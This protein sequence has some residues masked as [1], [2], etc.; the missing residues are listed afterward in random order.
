MET[1]V[2]NLLGA[3]GSRKSTVC[4]HVFAELKWNNI[5]CEIAL[6][7]AK[8]LV[9]EGNTQG[10]QNQLSILGE[11]YRRLQRL[12]GKVDVIVTDCPL[13]LN[14]LYA[15]KEK[16]IFHD[17]V[18]DRFC[19]FNNKNFLLLLPDDYVETGRVHTRLEAENIQRHLISELDTRS[20]PY[21]ISTATRKEVENIVNYILFL[22][23]PRTIYHSSDENGYS[24]DEVLGGRKNAR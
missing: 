9:W 2:V 7:Y 19:E 22:L 5:N 13:L 1:L 12:R 6:E 21:S 16:S 18:V 14:L 20:I 15:E 10:L 23:R 17:F 3:P 8:D 24:F 4:A 11:Q